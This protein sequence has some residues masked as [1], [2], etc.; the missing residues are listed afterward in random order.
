[1]AFFKKGLF[2]EE[3]VRSALTMADAYHLACGDYNEEIARQIYD[4]LPSY[5]IQLENW[6]SI[7]EAG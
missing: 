3:Q 5:V 4:Q 1:M 7:M 2:S 6:I